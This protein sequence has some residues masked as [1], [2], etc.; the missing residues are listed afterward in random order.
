M[1]PTRLKELL[2]ERDE[3]LQG[4]KKDLIARLLAWEK[5]NQS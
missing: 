4:S 1:N 3:S 5:T 2:K